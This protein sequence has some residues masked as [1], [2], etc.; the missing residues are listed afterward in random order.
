MKKT[1]IAIGVTAFLGIVLMLSGFAM[2]A[3]LGGFYLSKKGLRLNSMDYEIIKENDLGDIKR[4]E[5]NVSSIDVRFVTAETFGFEFRG[6]NNG[7]FSYSSEGGILRINE[8]PVFN[9]NFLDFTW[10]AE[11][12][13]IYVPEGAELDLV[14]II[15][16]SGNLNINRLNTKT[17]EAKVYSG[18]C[19]FNN[20]VSNDISINTLSGNVD[21]S[22][23]KAQTVYIDMKSGDVIVRN[24]EAGNLKMN[25]L[26]GNVNVAGK[27]DGNIDVESTSGDVDLNLK[28]REQDYNR[29]I[30]VLSGDVRVNGNRNSTG[31]VNFSAAYNLRIKTLSGNVE[32]NFTE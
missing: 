7:R 31:T 29:D 9:L 13:E 20:L 8:K 21:L 24:L 18:D 11:F 15:S 14:V 6:V 22:N 1:W 26:S 32:V 25:V 28:G 30:R 3:D 19:L 16:A 23:A 4:I 27:I 5:V 2:G 10:E 17:F 12:L